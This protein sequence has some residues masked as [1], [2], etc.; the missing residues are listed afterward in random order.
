MSHWE[1][2]YGSRKRGLRDN[3]GQ[4][5]MRWRDGR[6]CSAVGTDYSP[7]LLAAHIHSSGISLLFLPA[8]MN[9]SAPLEI[10]C[11]SAVDFYSATAEQAARASRCKVSL[12]A[13][14]RCVYA[15][16]CRRPVTGPFFIS[17]CWQAETEVVQSVMKEPGER[18]LIAEGQNYQGFHHH[19]HRQRWPEDDSAAM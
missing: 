12:R 3:T 18:S 13:S 2:G 14:H 4:E 11:Q 10:W 8:V 15:C 19:S 6:V 9:Q 5:G 7:L 17:W 16:V 1:G